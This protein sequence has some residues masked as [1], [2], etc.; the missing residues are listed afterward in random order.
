MVDKTAYIQKFKHL[1]LEIYKVSLSEELAV[2]YF[3]QLLTLITAIYYPS[4]IID[5]D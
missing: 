2:E 3:E 5:K 1:Y 4:L